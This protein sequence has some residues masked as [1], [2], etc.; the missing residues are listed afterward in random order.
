MNP[1]ETALAAQI[2]NR[3]AMMSAKSEK[4]RPAPRPFT[5][6]MQEQRKGGLHEDLSARMAEVVQAVME[7][8]KVGTVTVALKIKPIGDGQIQIFDDV[9]VKAP[10]GEKAPSIFY[11][12]SHGNVSRTDPRQTTLPLRQVGDEAVAANG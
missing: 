7:H 12:D 2:P 8:G 10:E 6:F 1:R 9:K 5:Q 3:K 4:E 11:T